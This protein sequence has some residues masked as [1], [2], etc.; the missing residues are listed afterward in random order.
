MEKP[1]LIVLACNVAPLT[2]NFL[3][4]ACLN[5]GDQWASFAQWAG[6]FADVNECV[7]VY[8]CVSVRMC[9]HH[10]SHC[11]GNRWHLGFHENDFGMD[12]SFCCRGLRLSGPSAWPFY[13]NTTGAPS[14]V[15]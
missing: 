6:A 12:P 13:L 11:V 7:F 15:P 10:P 4:G 8:E 3:R 5:K 1:A 2:D 9:S 14:V